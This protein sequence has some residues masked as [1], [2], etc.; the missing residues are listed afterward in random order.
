[1]RLCQQ[2]QDRLW[3][4]FINLEQITLSGNGGM[5]Y[6][7][8]L[9]ALP[10]LHVTIC[11]LY[12]YFFWNEGVWWRWSSILYAILIF[13][14]SLYSGWHY[15]IDGYIGFFIVVFVVWFTK[16]LAQGLH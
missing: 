4:A 5:A 7:M 9:M 3:E 6:G 13:L 11:L 14:G 2:V 1:M 15:A 10:S 8:G 12:V 16:K